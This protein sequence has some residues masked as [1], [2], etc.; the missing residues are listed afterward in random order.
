MRTLPWTLG[1][2]G[3]LVCCHLASKKS[4]IKTLYIG[5]FNLMN[6]GWRSNFWS[7]LWS[8]REPL[9]RR[10]FVIIFQYNFDK[11]GT[12]NQA[13]EQWLMNCI[14]QRGRFWQNIAWL[15]LLV[16]SNEKHFTQ[17]QHTCS[18]N[19]V[20]KPISDNVQGCGNDQMWVQS[21]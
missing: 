7:R 12:V 16:N 1:L 3:N 5:K 2:L 14:Q 19:L 11:V 15:F 9:L 6:F 10:W 4:P 8:R 21:G 17:Y 20:H 13:H 18:Y